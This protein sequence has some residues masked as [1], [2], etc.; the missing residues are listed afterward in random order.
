MWEAYSREEAMGLAMQDCRED[1]GLDPNATGAAE[2][3]RLPPGGSDLIKNLA[4]VDCN[5]AVC[6]A[7]L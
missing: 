7:W 3:F 5:L 4:T 2:G 1:L 6:Q